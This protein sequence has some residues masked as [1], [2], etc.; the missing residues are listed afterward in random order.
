M[1]LALEWKRASRP[2][3]IPSHAPGEGRRDLSRL[4]E[5]SRRARFAR[6]AFLLS[7]ATVLLGVTVLFAT[8]F[9]QDLAS[10]CE[11]KAREV[12]K[13]VQQE[14]LRQ[15]ELRAALAEA[16]SVREMERVAERVLGMVRGTDPV[17][18]MSEVPGDGES[19]IRM[20]PDGR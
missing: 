11:M 17:R 4:A 8:L 2:E 10:R 7:M 16:E 18:V 6:R 20:A 13:L 3:Q 9:V 14:R 19:A 12:E 1:S 15:E 5:R